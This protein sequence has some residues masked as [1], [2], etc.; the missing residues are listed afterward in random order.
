MILR[1]PTTIVAS[2]L[3]AVACKGAKEEA[4]DEK[5]RKSVV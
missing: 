2:L 3:I 1:R 5:D 4:G